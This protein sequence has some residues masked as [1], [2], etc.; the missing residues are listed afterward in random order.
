MKKHVYS[1]LAKIIKERKKV[2]PT[3]ETH[4][5]H[6]TKNE[7]IHERQDHGCPECSSASALKKNLKKER[8]NICNFLSCIYVHEYMKEP[9]FPDHSYKL[10]C[11]SSTST[12]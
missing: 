4:I 11:F 8:K 1:I 5:K 2:K 12:I 6:T 10:A 3:P 7:S 9:I